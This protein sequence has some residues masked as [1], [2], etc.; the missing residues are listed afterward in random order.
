MYIV[1]RPD[2]FEDDKRKTDMTGKF[3]YEVEAY[4][5]THRREKFPARD[6]G[7]A[8]EIAARICAEYLWVVNDD[9]TEEFFPPDKVYKVKIRK[10]LEG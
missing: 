3:M 9:G 2:I 8:R 5:G 10:L 6:L 4:L 1:C 7:N